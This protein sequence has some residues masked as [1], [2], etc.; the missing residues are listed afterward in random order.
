MSSPI[1][2]LGLGTMGRNLAL[3]I[4]DHGFHV[5]LWNRSSEKAEELATES[6][7][8][9][10]CAT[11][12]DVVAE[13]ATPRCLLLM[14]PAGAPVDELIDKL[15]PLLEPDDLLIDGGNS[16]FE[17]TQRRADSL[18]DAGIQ[19]LGLG[20]SGGED[21]ARHGPSLMPGGTPA[22]YE[23]VQPILEAIAAR[24]ESGPCVTYLGPD[25]A[26]HFVKMVH[27]G[28]EYAD[29]QLIAETSDVLRRG[30]GLTAAQAADVFAGWNEGPLESYLVEITAKILRVTQAGKP[31][32]DRVLD[33][34]GQKGTGRWTARVALELGVAV[35]TIAAAV[36][37][38]VLSA[39]RHERLAAAEILAEPDA[40]TIELETD[41]VGEALLA[42]RIIAYAQGMR[43]IQR[44]S[45]V[46]DWS[47]DLAE[48]ARIWKAGCIIRA[49]LLDGLRRAWTEVPALSN[50][51]L[52]HDLRERVPGTLREVV[53]PALRAGIPMPAFS[54]S[55]AWYD[56]V[57]TDRLPTSLI[58][59]Q[60]DAFGAHGYQ[61][62]DDPDG[63]SVHTE[64]LA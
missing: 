62:I 61:R 58:Q 29:M 14:V 53:G 39:D 64:W 43:L 16:Y 13:L 45:E 12:E 30:L 26:G 40:E 34:A 27:N 22:A 1:A 20:V 21:G 51:V 25:G 15:R 50:L 59:A 63:E 2:V 33:Q 52:D 37:A 42:A 7:R 6:E 17:E 57:R 8:F 55:L 18:S 9:V 38:R 35:P 31:L 23:R 44:A 24:S 56:T 5:A 36:D 46:H 60:R 49:R 28:I 32:V 48:V 54:A 19:Y 41:A 11:L 4:S 10:A 3:N 47:I